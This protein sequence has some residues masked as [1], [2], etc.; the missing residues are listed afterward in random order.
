VPIR[1]RLALTVAVVAAIMVAAGGNLFGHQLRA[2]VGG[3]IDDSLVPRT[4]A[5]AGALASSRQP[6]APGDLT[7]QL[8]GEEQ[9][10]QVLDPAGEVVM[11]SGSLAMQP[12]LTAAD[13]ASVA[14]SGP[15]AFT[16][17]LRRSREADVIRLSATPVAR[18][19]GT[20]FVVLGNSLHGSELALDRVHYFLWIGGP[21]AVLAAAA[22][23]W[24]LAGAA[25]RPV[26]RMRRQVTAITEHGTEATIEPPRTRDELARM[27][28]TVNDLLVRLYD[29]RGRDRR[30]IADAGH[31]LRT[32]LAVLR[33]ELELAARPGRSADDLRDSVQHA[34]L[35][36]DRLARLAANLLFLARTDT[37]GMPRAEPTRVRPV[38]EAAAGATSQRA[39]S[40]R[41]DVTVRAAHELV[42]PCDA[43]RLRQ[44]LDNLLDNALRVAPSGS[45]VVLE[46]RAE[47]PWCEVSVLDGGPGFPERFLPRAFERFSRPESERTSSTGGAGLGLAIVDAIARGHGGWATAANRPGGG[48]RVTLGL[49]LALPAT[50]AGTSES[51]PSAAPRSTR[52]EDADHASPAE[53][54]PVV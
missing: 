4:R 32:P 33:T 49:P 50:L 9:L 53:P 24:F 22:G 16:W 12:M 26:E 3:S 28:A 5:I 23:A 7:A 27:T 18:S 19:D 8:V 10:A 13:L 43:D 31:E 21:I 44:A 38:L 54:D 6:G 45:A 48:A 36:V 47:P 42:V 51:R 1:L 25:L 2:S 29:A 14:A 40:L 35:E 20:W 30:L 37:S 41:I 34:A 46:A 11:A 39:S 17:G 15:A 52:R